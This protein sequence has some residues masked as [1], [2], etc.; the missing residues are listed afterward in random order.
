MENKLDAVDIAGDLERQI[1]RLALLG[2]DQHEVQLH[3]M[4]D[5][6]VAPDDAERLPILNLGVGHAPELAPQENLL[7]PAI[8]DRFDSAGEVGVEFLDP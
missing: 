6:Q 4:P 1:R 5:R 8:P 7:A 3:W 2:L